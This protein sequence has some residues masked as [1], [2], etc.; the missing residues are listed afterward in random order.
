MDC[1]GPEEP[2]RG[3]SL[4][5][6][7]EAAAALAEARKVLERNAGQ[8]V[9]LLTF[10]RGQLH[11]LREGAVADEA[12]VGRVEVLT[13]DACQGSEFD[14]VVLSPVRSSLGTKIERLAFLKEPSMQRKQRG[15]HF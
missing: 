14:H 13:V 4:R 12:L 6:E 5:N 1:A 15:W 10:Y 11:E 3:K 7:A 9:A 8:S 2:A